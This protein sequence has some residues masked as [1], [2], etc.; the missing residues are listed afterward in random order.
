MHSRS[1]LLLP[2]C[3]NAGQR[4]R[5]A[6]GC[7]AAERAAGGAPRAARCVPAHGCVRFRGACEG[8]FALRRSPL[9]GACT[10]HDCSGVRSASARAQRQRVCASKAVLRGAHTRGGDVVRCCAQAGDS[11][12]DVVLFEGAPN[13][14]KATEA[15]APRRPLRTQ[16][17]RVWRRRALA[18]APLR[19]LA[20]APL[21]AL[22]PPLRSRA[23]CACAT[24]S[25]AKKASS[26]RCQAL[27]RPAAARRVRCALGATRRRVSPPISLA[28][29]AT[30]AAA[31]A[32]AV[33]HCGRGAAEGERR[34]FG[35]LH[36]DQR[37]VRAPLP[38]SQALDVAHALRCVPDVACALPGS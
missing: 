15:R 36:G 26:L 29:R 2:F 38:G 5:R 30:L 16:H 33:V 22:T 31:D 18:R 24:C 3:A 27:S 35:R 12:P 37:P 32:P 10:M 20:R 21:R 25:R 4:V 14:G 6:R 9:C 11:L 19:A 13:Y 34:G 17:S 8:A 7:G 23:R 28:C 1:A